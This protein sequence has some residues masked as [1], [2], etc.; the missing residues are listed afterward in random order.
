LTFEGQVVTFTPSGLFY[1]ARVRMI[2]SLRLYFDHSFVL[3]YFIYAYKLI[4]IGYYNFLQ[5]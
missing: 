5:I 4:I 2:W 1:L 3:F